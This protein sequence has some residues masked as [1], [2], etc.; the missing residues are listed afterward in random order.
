M[1]IIKCQVYLIAYRNLGSDE[2]H[3]TLFLSVF[4]RLI[5]GWT[6]M[7]SDSTDHKGLIIVQD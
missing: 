4:D 7:V 5:I 6:V 1:S 3:G 2:W